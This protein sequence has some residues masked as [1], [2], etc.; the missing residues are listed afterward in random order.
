MILVSWIAV[1]DGGG[2]EIYIRRGETGV[3]R[4]PIEGRPAAAQLHLLLELLDI[5]KGPG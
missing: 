4:N 2:A 3:N 1:R 5:E